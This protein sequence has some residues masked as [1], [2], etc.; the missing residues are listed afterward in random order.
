MA[1]DN[2]IVGKEV[3]RMEVYVKTK[4]KI[5]L[6][7]I[8]VAALAIMMIGFRWFFF[9][10]LKSDQM[11]WSFGHLLSRIWSLEANQECILLKT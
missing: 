2:I 7:V 5:G 4:K 9:E 11:L 8:I 3:K 1:D 10:V 6:F